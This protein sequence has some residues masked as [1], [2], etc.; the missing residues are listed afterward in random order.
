MR[1]LKSI[2]LAGAMLLAFAGPIFSQAVPSTQEEFIARMLDDVGRIVD[3][4]KIQITSSS[5]T[6]TDQTHTLAGQCNFFDLLNVGFNAKFDQGG[7]IRRFEVSVPL[8]PKLSADNMTSILKSG[9][10][11]NLFLPDDVKKSLLV[12]KYFI[13]FTNTLTIDSVGVDFA[14]PSSIKIF[15]LSALKLTNMSIGYRVA[16]PLTQPSVSGS[17]D[18]TVAWGLTNPIPFSMQTNLVRDPKEWE[19]RFGIGNLSFNTIFENLGVEKPLIPPG[20]NNLLSVSSA[21]LAI[22][23]CAY[24]FIFSGSSPLGNVNIL[25]KRTTLEGRDIATDSSG[26]NSSLE[27]DPDPPPNKPPPVPPTQY[28]WGVMAGFSLPESNDE[29]PAIRTMRKIGLTNIA[30]VVSTIDEELETSLPIF[31]NLGSGSTTI[32]KG[33]SFVAWIPVDDL[34]NK[35]KLT[36]PLRTFAPKFMQMLSSANPVSSVMFRANVSAVNIGEFSLE[37]DINFND[38]MSLKIKDV[39]IGRL[40]QLKLA[41]AVTPTSQSVELSIGALWSMLLDPTRNAPLDFAASMFVKTTGPNMVTMGFSGS[42]NSL[43]Q[44]AYGIPGIS[45][46]AL[47]FKSGMNITLEG[48]LPI[49]YPDDL[50]FTGQM[51]YGQSVGEVTVAI[52]P[53]EPNQNMFLGRVC[54]LSLANLVSQFLQRDVKSKYESSKYSYLRV[55]NDFV[56][57]ELKDAYLKIVPPG[58]PTSLRSGLLLEGNLMSQCPTT[59]KLSDNWEPGIRIAANGKF[60]NLEGLFDVGIEGSLSALQGGLT[61]RGKLSPI[62]FNPNNVTVFEL[63]GAN[64]SDSAEIFL[65]LSTNNMINGVKSLLLKDVPDPAIAGTDRIFF[66]NARVNFFNTLKGAARVELTPGGYSCYMKTKVFNLVDATV[67][68]NIGSFRDFINTTTVSVSLE[69]GK[70]Q[71]KLM[72]GLSSLFGGIPLI[73]DCLNTFRFESFNTTASLSGWN[74]YSR[75][76]IKFSIAGDKHELD[77]NVKLN[78]LD[79][80]VSNICAAIKDKAMA[81]FG[82]IA[83]IA[84]DVINLAKD[85][86]LQAVSLA[87]TTFNNAVEDAQKISQTVVSVAGTAVATVRS[88]TLVAWNKCIDFA[89][90]FGRFTAAIVSKIYRNTLALLT[91]GVGGNDDKRKLFMKNGPGYRIVTKIP[92]MIVQG[93]PNTLDNTPAQLAPRQ[94]PPNTPMEQIWQLVPH[95]TE[96]QFFLVSAYNG[97]LLTKARQEQGKAPYYCFLIP[98]ESDHYERE[99]LV[100]EQVPDEMGWYYLKYVNNNIYMQLRTLTYAF[101]GRNNTTITTMVAVPSRPVS[102][103][104]K[105]HFD[106]AGNIVWNPAGPGPASMIPVEQWAERKIFQFEGE[107]EKYVYFG[108]VLRLLPDDETIAGVRLTPVVTTITPDMRVGAIIGDPIPSFRNGMVYRANN[109]AAIYYIKDGKRRWIPDMETFSMM[110]IQASDVTSIPKADLELIQLGDPIPVKLLP[111]VKLLDNGIYQA[112]GDPTVYKVVAQKLRAFPDAETFGYMGY[113]FDMVVKVTPANLTKLPK[114]TPFPTRKQW[115]LIRPNPMQGL[116]RTWTIDH[117]V[118][119]Q[120]PFDQASWDYMKF[121]MRNI[122]TIDYNDFR[123]I[124]EGAPI[125]SVYDQ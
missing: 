46:N 119:R 61:L 50:F 62:R 2:L 117:G 112:D 94:F 9:D 109:E 83:K 77:V 8:G 106:K 122:K 17:F 29:V 104:G 70:L 120:L 10:W 16:N 37:G 28:K 56:N 72:S 22:R 68:A 34:L 88:I 18:A 54:N 43:W 95:T 39:E 57:M 92:G 89:K 14:I 23:P 20:V 96:G 60:A 114:G 5:L 27:F 31:A 97:R 65:D 113:S 19:L 15:N 125:K 84:Q 59:M 115:T 7:L 40:S 124:P 85:V 75:A 102:D 71:D 111:D 6:E 53:N 100:M 101:D 116:V 98:H 44:N 35:Y 93:Q 108:G 107:T 55:L 118:K 67:N 42:M 13:N 1:P 74:S 45:F 3:K 32:Q 69:A 36:Q 123:D 47:K 51:Q 66:L 110:K 4:A 21:E 11:M 79:E 91:K 73:K 78:N 26:E 99:L 41:V 90:E 63:T 48:P 80:M 24:T 103:S 30:L 25:V 58:A 81:V 49:A 121:D 82:A 87:K 33:F 64:G 38:N 12:S 76:K 105:F 52:N 86:T